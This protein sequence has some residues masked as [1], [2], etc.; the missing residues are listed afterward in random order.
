MD[1]MDRREGEGRKG[2][3]GDGK[4]G[5]EDAAVAGRAAGRMGSWLDGLERTSPSWR[6]SCF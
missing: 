1:E 4:V 6:S 3:L 5:S 2:R